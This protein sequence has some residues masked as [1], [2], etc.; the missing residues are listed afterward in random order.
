MIAN[1]DER[2]RSDTVTLCLDINAKLAMRLK[3]VSRVEKCSQDAMVN[4]ILAEYFQ[5]IDHPTDRLGGRD[6]R[7]HIRKDVSIPGVIEIKLTNNETQ[8]KP[9]SIV[10]ISLGGIGITMEGKTQR[11]LDNINRQVPFLIIFS[12]PSI[13]EII[14]MLC[15]PI[16]ITMNSATEIGAAFMKMPDEIRSTLR[17]HFQ[18]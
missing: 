3:S 16:H 13:S 15:K 12:I 2:I 5:E 14:H 9:V 8:Y 4:T 10:N 18:L 17:T 6:F 7:K 11:V 1:A